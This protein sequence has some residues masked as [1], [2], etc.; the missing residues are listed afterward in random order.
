MTALRVPGGGTAADTAACSDAILMSDN[1]V[2]STAPPFSSNTVQ[3]STLQ[4]CSRHDVS[5]WA[6]AGVGQY[7]AQTTSYMRPDRL[8]HAN[9]GVGED[10]GY[11]ISRL[12]WV[13][14]LVRP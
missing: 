10:M 13:Q 11:A 4:H 3:S 6:T 7:A 5:V 12:L 14:Y 2:V 9:A 8:V 1:S